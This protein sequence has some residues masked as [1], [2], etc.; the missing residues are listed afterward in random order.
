LGA[1]PAQQTASAVITRSSTID[2]IFN[3]PLMLN[4]SCREFKQ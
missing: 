3:A 4:K 2:R 1:A